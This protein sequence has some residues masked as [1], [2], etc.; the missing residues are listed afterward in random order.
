MPNVRTRAVLCIRA[1]RLH[2]L[3]QRAFRN[4]PRAVRV[5]RLSS[6]NVQYVGGVNIR[7]RMPELHPWTHFAGWCSHCVRWVLCWL[8][9]F[10]PWNVGVCSMSG[11][12]DSHGTGI[13]VNVCV[14]QLQRW[15]VLGSSWSDSVRGLPSRLLQ[16][17]NG[18]CVQRV[19]PAMSAR[20][21]CECHPRFSVC[22]LLGWILCGLHCH[23]CLQ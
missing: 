6:R 2:K 16:P 10:C 3:L 8:F 14:L 15:I 18:L 21:L 11:W 13:N 23:N 19:M 1:E 20:A 4:D 17:R 5:R 9:C 22:Q 12:K 7:G